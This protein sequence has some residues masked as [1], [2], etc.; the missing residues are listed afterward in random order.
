[1]FGSLV[2]SDVD[3]MG[4]LVKREYA[5]FLVDLSG[6]GFGGNGDYADLPYAFKVNYIYLS[7]QCQFHLEWNANGR[8]DECCVD[9]E[10]GINV[11]GS[12]PN[13]VRTV[14]EEAH[15]RFV[16]M[17]ARGTIDYAWGGTLVTLPVENG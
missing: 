4:N 14:E 12:G 3:G 13:E 7:C 17:T 8:G 9:P 10:A 5:N 2:R 6:G 15:L 1:M 11:A 16:C